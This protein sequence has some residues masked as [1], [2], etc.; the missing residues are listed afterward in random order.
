MKPKA[1]WALVLGIVITGCGGPE[2]PLAPTSGTVKFEGL[3]VSN[4]YAVTIKFIPQDAG[5]GGMKTPPTATGNVDPATGAFEVATSQ[6][7]PGAV[8]GKNKV[9]VLWIKSY[10]APTEPVQLKV[11]PAEVEIGSGD[12]TNLQFTVTKP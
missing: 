3:D 11:T 7:D 8:I 1:L 6:G 9:E 12:S 5:G 2:F 4:S 10:E